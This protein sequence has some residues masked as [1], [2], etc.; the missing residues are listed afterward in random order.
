MY[1]KICGLRTEADVAAAVDAGSDAV[2]FVFAESVRKVT[3]ETA[4]RLAA[5]APSHVLTVGVFRGAS[6]AEAARIA[7]DAG[8][9]AIQLHGRY[10]RSAFQELGALPFR[11][12]RAI[13]LETGIAP[14]E[15]AA[16]TAVGAY[17]EDF[18]LLDSPDAGS[19]TRWDVSK[20]GAANLDGPWLLAGGL[21]AANVAAAVAAAHP[22]GV[23]VSSGVES[24]RGIKDPQLIREFLAAVRRCEN[25]GD[26]RPRSVG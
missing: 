20:T 9:D 6:A 14:Q 3:P 19:G 7:S 25:A 11:L 21:N 16:G 5:E 1:V 24:S 10:P 12:I 8:L 22:W 13:S 17:G 26:A 23:D 18:L 4:R 15:L 2:G